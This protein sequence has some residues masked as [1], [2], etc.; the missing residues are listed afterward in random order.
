[1]TGLT[2]AGLAAQY[3]SEDGGRWEKKTEKAA[4]QG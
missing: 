3:W 4:R 2:G 1:W